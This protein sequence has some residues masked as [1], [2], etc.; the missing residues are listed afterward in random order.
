M[1]VR[2]A[3]H[4]H[5]R[6]YVLLDI[7][8]PR[9]SGYFP[10]GARTREPGD[11]KFCSSHGQDPVPSWAKPRSH[12]HTASCLT[13]IRHT[14]PLCRSLH[15]APLLL[16]G[17]A[18]APVCPAPLLCGCPLALLERALLS[19]PQLSLPRAKTICAVVRGMGSNFPS[20]AGQACRIIAGSQMSSVECWWP[21]QKGTALSCTRLVQ[22]QY[23]HIMLC[24]MCTWQCGFISCHC[25]QLHGL[26]GTGVP[27]SG[28]CRLLPQGE[29]L[30]VDAS[31]SQLI[32]LAVYSVDQRNEDDGKADAHN[33][34]H[35]PADALPV[36]SLGR[37]DAADPTTGR[38]IDES[39]RICDSRKI[40]DTLLRYVSEKGEPSELPH[41]DL[42]PVRSCALREHLEA[43]QRFN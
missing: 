33:P 18:G 35:D 29:A 28:S 4:H 11:A 41:A 42:S 24:P 36:G 27:P 14:S 12:Y 8:A 32:D 2:S 9:M 31:C 37:H 19:Q 34:S 13:L 21:M 38:E 23:G 16:A 43:L 26:C 17:A 15:C 39:E 25:L 20:R 30:L 6:Y 7:G 10:V 22:A 3:R 40:M 1:A 5:S